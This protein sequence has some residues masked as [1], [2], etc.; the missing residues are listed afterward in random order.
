[1]SDFSFT[2][3]F[4]RAASRRHNLVPKCQVCAGTLP[5]NPRLCERCQIWNDAHHVFF[6]FGPPYSRDKNQS[7][8]SRELTD[9]LSNPECMLCQ[10][11]ASSI[12]K[13]IRPSETGRK[14]V[15]ISGPYHFDG[16]WDVRVTGL[17]KLRQEGQGCYTVKCIIPLILDD[18]LSKDDLIALFRATHNTDSHR[19]LWPETV[20]AVQVVLCY[21]KPMEGLVEIRRWEEPFLDIRPLQELLKLCETEHLGP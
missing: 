17:P 21:Q 3:E 10:I 2:R 7:Y 18:G 12:L 14:P 9:L 19:D 16:D 20:M 11:I 13:K 8:A 4:I 5:L 15:I 1:M 6:C